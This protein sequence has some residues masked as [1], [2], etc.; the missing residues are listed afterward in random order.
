MRL[1]E[2]LPLDELV[3][4]D[5]WAELDPETRR[6]AAEALYRGGASSESG[7]RHADVALAARL[8]FREV[9]VRRLPVERRVQYLVGRVR[10]DDALAS[11]LLLAMHLDHRRSLLEAFL[12]AARDPEPERP[13]PR[14]P[15]S[16]P[17]RGGTARRRRRGAVREPRRG[18]GRPVPGKPRGDGPARLERPRADPARPRSGDHERPRVTVWKPGARLTHRHNPD[19]GVGVVQRGR[20][21]HASSCSFRGRDP[22][23]AW[24]RT[25]T[26]CG[27]SCSAPARAC[28]SPRRA[29]RRSSPRSRTTA[30]SCSTT[31]GARAWPSCGPSKRADSPF[32]RLARGDVDDARGVRAAARRAAP[33]ASCARPTASARSSAAGSG[34]SRTS[35]TSPS[36]RRAADPVRWLLADEVGLG[37]TVEACLILNHLRRDRPRRAHARRR[38]R[39]ARRCSGWASCGASTTRCSCCSTTQRLADVERDFGAGFNPFEAHRRASSASSDSPRRRDSPSGGRGRDRPVDRRRGASPAPPAGHPGDPAYRAI[40]PDRRARPARAAA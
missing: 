17:A 24:R 38:S 25:R 40:A 20:C 31:A 32:D 37:K 6:R 12:D 34:S 5:I 9:A 3:P 26:L 36:A 4:S 22:R 21:P 13:D 35:S 23:C 19:L 11:S 27:R 1:L 39:D 28:G 33:R 2:R 14:R 7:R 30:A 10:P 18:R 15:R 29:R 16:A 8:N